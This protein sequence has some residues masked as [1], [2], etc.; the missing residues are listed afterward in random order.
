VSNPL[1][2]AKHY[3]DRAE[4]CLRLSEIVSPQKVKA[5][6]E[7]MARQ[8]MKLAKVE[9]ALFAGETLPAHQSQ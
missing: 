4:E 1:S 2:R 3:R 6:Y 9:D 5:E 8:Y 7:A